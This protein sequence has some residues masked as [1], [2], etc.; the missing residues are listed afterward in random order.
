MSFWKQALI[1]L[2][3][4]ALAFFGWVRFFPGSS[5][6]LARWGMDWVPFATVARAPDQPAGQGNGQ[7]QRGAQQGVVA[8]TVTEETINDRLSAIGTGRAKQTVAVTP[9]AAGRMTEMLVTSGATVKR[10][11]WGVNTTRGIKRPMMRRQDA[12]RQSPLAVRKDN[13]GP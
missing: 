9:Y 12:P 10:R 2:I 13:R 4:L 3:V 6:I 5:E 8:A 11:S 7:R 1:S